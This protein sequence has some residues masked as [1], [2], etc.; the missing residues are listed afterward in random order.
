MEE[1]QSIIKR[2]VSNYLKTPLK[3]WEVHILSLITLWSLILFT[4]SN[5]CFFGRVNKQHRI[6][7]VDWIFL[8]YFLFLY[9]WPLI[10]V[11][12][13]QRQGCLCEFEGDLIYVVISKTAR[14]M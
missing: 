10:P 14:A 12:K 3:I 8:N 4:L 5:S 11:I 9:M 13:K 1:L 2:C 6:R 7:K